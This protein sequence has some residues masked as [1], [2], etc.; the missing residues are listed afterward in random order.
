MSYGAS[1]CR[2]TRSSSE[3]DGSLTDVPGIRVGPGDGAAPWLADG[4]HGGAHRRRS[5]RRG[6]RTRRWS[7]HPRDRP[8]ASGEPGAARARRS[9]SPVAVPTGWR[10]ATGVM[11]ELEARGIGFPV[12]AAPT[13][14]VV[15]IVPGR[16]HLRP[17]P[18]W[19]VREPTRRERSVLVRC[20]R[21]EPSVAEGAVGAGTGAI[22][23]SL[24]GGVGT[25]SITLADGTV[26][27]ALAVVNSVGAVIDPATGLPWVRDGPPTPAPSRRRIEP[28]SPARLEAVRAPLNTTIGVVATSIA[29]TKAEC[30]KMAGVAH[31]GMATSDPTVAHVVRRRHRVRAV[32]RYRRT[33]SC[34]CARGAS[35][36]GRAST[37]CS[38]Q[39]PRASRS[40]A[41]VR[42]SA[43]RSVAR[44]ATGVPRPVPAARPHHRDGVR[45]R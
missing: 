27:G 17:R 30:S 37:S 23:G 10:A 26:V 39:V 40:P 31:D 6:R 32:D 18:R 5:R 36:G 43:A 45:G 38:R 11:A 2:T 28:R 13:A 7:G 8:A 20:A 44:R 24:Q 9:V 35:S 4:H 33:R 19:R 25:A 12:G 21:H 22:A 42:C 41:H 14:G 15:P 34:R 3:S 16:G 29:L 1:S